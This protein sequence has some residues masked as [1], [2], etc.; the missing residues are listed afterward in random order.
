LQSLRS[1]ECD[2]SRFGTPFILLP[3][4]AS[5]ARDT[6]SNY[7]L[8]GSDPDARKRLAKVVGSVGIRSVFGLYQHNSAQFSPE[9][10][11]AA[12]GVSDR[13]SFELAAQS[14]DHQGPFNKEWPPR[15]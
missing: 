5:L 4:N 12:R 10:L 2:Q 1:I 8:T 14:L 13:N 7:V 15:H 9:I 3:G 6:I 11:S